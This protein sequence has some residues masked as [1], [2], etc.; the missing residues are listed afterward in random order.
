MSED[1]Y[2]K[3]DKPSPKPSGRV[4]ILVTLVSMIAAVGLSWFAHGAAYFPFDLSITHCVQTLESPWF[5]LPLSVLSASGFVPLVDAI[6]GVILLILFFFARWRWESIVTAIV[7]VFASGVS[8]LVKLIV[9][10]PRPPEG[11]VRVGRHIHNS[12]YPAGHVLNLTAFAGLLCYFTWT[13]LA[14]SWRRSAVIAILLALIG[15]MGLARIDAGEHWMSDVLGGFL[16]GL[17]CVAAGI[18]LDHWGERK[19][20]A[21]R[22]GSRKTPQ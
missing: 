5:V 20:W 22:V 8:H 18:A 21:E 12:S 14:P 2:P 10:R 9:A 4:L 15:L 3:T 1:R 17:P 16:Y 6:Y 13:R 7:A 19:G 11:L